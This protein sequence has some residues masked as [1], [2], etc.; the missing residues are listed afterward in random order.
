MI[1]R[2]DKLYNLIRP[3]LEQYRYERPKKDQDFQQILL[4]KIRY[5]EL[6]EIA[7]DYVKKHETGL[8]LDK[9]FKRELISLK[10]ESAGKSI[11][12]LIVSITKSDPFL[13]NSLLEMGLSRVH[14]GEAR[15]KFR[16]YVADRS[17]PV[18]SVFFDYNLIRQ[19]TV[20]TVKNKKGELYERKGTQE[21]TLNDMLRQLS[22][23]AYPDI[24]DKVKNL[25]KTYVDLS[26]D[27]DYK[28]PGTTYLRESVV[29][30]QKIGKLI[31]EK[32]NVSDDIKHL[33]PNYN[34]RRIADK[35]GN[36][37]SGTLSK[38]QQE[39][40][41]RQIRYLKSDISILEDYGKL[42]QQLGESFEPAKNL[43]VRD[44]ISEYRKRLS[45]RLQEISGNAEISKK[46]LAYLD[47]VESKK[48]DNPQLYKETVEELSKDEKIGVWR[49]KQWS[50][51][52]KFVPLTAW[53]SKAADIEKKREERR[54]V[55]FSGETTFEDFQEAWKDPKNRGLATWV[56][57]TDKDGN[58]ILRQDGTPVM[59]PKGVTKVEGQFFRT[60][61]DDELLAVAKQ[62]RINRLKTA[63][64]AELEQASWEDFNKK[65]QSDDPKYRSSWYWREE[66]DADGKVTKR[67]L[68]KVISFKG[69]RYREGI[70]DAKLQQDYSAAVAED[71]ARISAAR[72]TLISVQEQKIQQL[73]DIIAKKKAVGGDTTSL[74][75]LLKKKQEQL[76]QQRTKS[77]DYEGYKNYDK[78]VA[79]VKS[80]ADILS[81]RAD[82][83]QQD[84]NFNF[85]KLLG[86]KQD[87]AARL[88]ALQDEGNELRLTVRPSVETY[89]WRFNQK[90][91]TVPE[92]VGRLPLKDQL[93]WYRTAETLMSD[94]NAQSYDTFK[95]AVNSIG[96]QQLNRNL[97]VKYLRKI[98]GSGIYRS[99]VDADI[100][101]EHDR[102]RDYYKSR[103][104][105]AMTGPAAKA[106][107]S[108][109]KNSFGA[110][111][112]QKTPVDQQAAQ[113]ALS[114]FNSAPDNFSTAYGNLSVTARKFYDRNYGTPVKEG[115]DY[116]RSIYDMSDDAW[117]RAEKAAG[118]DVPRQRGSLISSDINV[119]EEDKLQ[120][121]VTADLKSR[122]WEP[123]KKEDKTVVAAAQE[124]KLEEIVVSARAEQET[125]N[126]LRR[127]LQ[128]AEKEAKRGGIGSMGLMGAFVLFNFAMT[129]PSHEAE[130]HRRRVEE[131]RRIKK[132][133]YNYQ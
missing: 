64:R 23:A 112:Q 103:E 33:D 81:A 126:N 56:P 71:Q 3:L 31:A 10:E 53:Y 9:D 88:K 129:G 122:T 114:A 70:D 80:A 130:E 100:I 37:E 41:D 131:E 54:N 66:T 12:D 83:L 44:K 105:R 79:A 99:T 32:G 21:A 42:T 78:R 11:D 75:E 30:R 63:T 28:I 8:L 38:E 48:K 46:S 62:E 65:I 2:D 1:K 132:Y 72:Q 93:S 124:K 107:P 49:A 4:D 67:Y 85:V 127:M 20:R 52:Q 95:A 91:L 82:I 98:K 102:I 13:R 89:R 25:R 76:E 51:E 118:Y 68:D 115:N 57:A 123:V 104:E 60:G 110:L 116:Y 27:N 34:Y 77:Y 7:S 86:D 16:S 90:G 106:Q 109:V 40:L 45:G 50:G 108:G 15:E 92:R 47:L 87:Y 96:F 22:D 5:P 39:F 97:P 120:Q 6:Q 73:S 24:E 26:G 69:N 111:L 101:A 119:A 84:P 59:V 125:K 55:L 35:I 61:V 19:R 133:G 58:Q 121:E 43:S 36:L 29:L 18:A 113:E 17:M 14:D 128:R 117:A 74:E 94:I